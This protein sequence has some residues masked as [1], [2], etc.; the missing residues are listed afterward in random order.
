MA[1]SD[2]DNL[3]VWANRHSEFGNVQARIVLELLDERECIPLSIR[4]Y[5]SPEAMLDNLVYEYDAEI[6][7]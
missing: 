1:Q 3:R 6:S 4:E 5:V 2:L 7:Q